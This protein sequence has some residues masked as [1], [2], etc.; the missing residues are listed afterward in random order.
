MLLL[1]L[2]ETADFFVSDEDH[3]AAVID[4]GVKTLRDHSPPGGWL[5]SVAL[6]GFG[7]LGT[8]GDYEPPDPDEQS[9]ADVSWGWASSLSYSNIDKAQKDL[10]KKRKLALDNGPYQVGFMM[11]KVHT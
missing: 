4:Y 1:P 8:F 7:V 3:L 6:F 11:L 5:F 10:F 2:P 9:Q